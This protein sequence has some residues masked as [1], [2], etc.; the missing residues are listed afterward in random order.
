MSRA[1][2][3][4]WSGS[5]GCKHLRL[6]T[7]GARAWWVYAAAAAGALAWL[8]LIC[9]APRLLASGHETSA[10]LLYVGF[11]GVC[12]QLPERSF[13]LWGCP[14]AVCARCAGL[15]AGSLAGLLLYPLVRR[16]SDE[17]FPDRRWLLLAAAPLAVDVAGGAAGL[18]VNTFF[19]RAATGALAGAAAACYVLPGMISCVEFWF[20][21]RATRHGGS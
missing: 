9:A 8:G 15:Y 18:F 17:T 5:I 7:G 19:S 13:H 11:S 12:H 6:E 3:T 2:R 16:V 1:G 20:R 10:A 21:G 14:L 4:R